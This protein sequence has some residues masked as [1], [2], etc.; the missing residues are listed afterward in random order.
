M[1]KVPDTTSSESDLPHSAS[2]AVSPRVSPASSPGVLYTA[3]SETDLSFPEVYPCLSSHLLIS[4]WDCHSY[5]PS[6]LTQEKRTSY[7]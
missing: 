3:S 4:L 5:L 6:G 7:H 2:N 1:G